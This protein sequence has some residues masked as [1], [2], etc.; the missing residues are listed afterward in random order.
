[1]PIPPSVRV[2][3][4]R[5]RSERRCPRERTD[6]RATDK[7]RC[8]GSYLAG[9]GLSVRFGAFAAAKRSAWRG[10][11]NPAAAVVNRRQGLVAVAR[12]LGAT[13]DGGDLG[14]GLVRLRS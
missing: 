10:G 8:A 13:I 6:G 2:V 3:A 11:Q 14:R 12:P 9:R 4:W 5:V 7:A 1:M